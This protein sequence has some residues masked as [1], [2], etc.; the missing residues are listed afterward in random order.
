MRRVAVVAAGLAGLVTGSLAAFALQTEPR[1]ALPASETRPEV[2]LPGGDSGVLLVWTSGGLPAGLAGD[3]GRIPGVTAVT[4]VA[5]GRLDLVRSA[6][7]DGRALDRPPPGLAIALDAIAV[8]VATYPPFVPAG[9]RDAFA[10]LAPG[11]ALLGATSASLRRM[12]A[13]GSIELAQGGRLTVA[14]V[15]PDGTVGAAEV[16]VPSHWAQDAGVLRT[17]RYALVSYRGDRAPID[18]AVRNAVADRLPVRIRGPGETPFVREG[19]AVL[20]QALI[21]LRFGEFASVPGSGTDLVQDPAWV[22]DNIVTA[23]VPLLGRVHCH[24]SLVPALR[25]AMREL[26]DRNLAFL[27]DAVSFGGCWVPGVVPSGEAPSRHAWGVAFDLNQRKNMTGVTSTQDPRLVE[28]LA[29]WGFTSGADWLVP[30]A[31]YFEYVRPPDPR[32]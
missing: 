24:R 23:D 10:S 6:G 15:V 19:D 11:E 25:G 9:V 16:V 26:A 21:K 29:R 13:G 1:P 18:T 2:P 28:V 32:R 7:G 20:P 8:D 14:A 5:G 22:A 4:S 12:E 31:A 17:P 30:D 27:V 3:I